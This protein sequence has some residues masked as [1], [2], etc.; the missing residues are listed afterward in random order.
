MFHS[1]GE[2][3]GVGLGREHVARN[4]VPLM[5]P[6]FQKEAGKHKGDGAGALKM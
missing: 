2:Q 3:S 4:H 1:P 6:V 5:N